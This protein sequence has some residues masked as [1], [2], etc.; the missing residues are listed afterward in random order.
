MSKTSSVIKNAVAMGDDLVI[1]FTSGKVYS[2][3]GMAPHVGSLLAADS[4]GTYFNANVR[5]SCRGSL[6]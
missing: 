4:R 5:P 3:E 1:E 6:V 2:Y